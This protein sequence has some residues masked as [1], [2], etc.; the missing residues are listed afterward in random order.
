[1]AQSRYKDGY[2][3]QYIGS[4]TPEQFKA[5]TDEQYAA[6]NTAWYGNFGDQREQK[7]QLL[8]DTAQEY[9][10]K[11]EKKQETPPPAKTPAK[12]NSN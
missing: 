3:L 6:N 7:L 8:Y 11:K 5:E 10:G 9:V 2:D 1:M 12:P 4:L